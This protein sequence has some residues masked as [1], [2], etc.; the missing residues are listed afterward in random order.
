M[1]GE[2]REMEKGRE[3][4]PLSPGPLPFSLSPIVTLGTQAT[5]RPVLVFAK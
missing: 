2:K 4:H 3:R 1:E 5:L